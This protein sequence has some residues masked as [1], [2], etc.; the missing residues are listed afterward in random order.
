LPWAWWRSCCS[1]RTGLSAAP[2][3]HLDAAV[4]LLRLAIDTRGL[5]GPVN[6]VALHDCTQ[7]EFAQAMAVAYGRRAWLRVPAAPLRALGGEMM[8]LMLE[9]QAVAPIASA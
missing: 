7:R 5:T 1:C 8:S 4:G 2:W 3:L 9:G 6:A